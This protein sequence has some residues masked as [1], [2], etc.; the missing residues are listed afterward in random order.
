[1]Q[2]KLYKEQQH[3][4]YIRPY[5]AKINQMLSKY[6]KHKAQNRAQTNAAVEVKVN[7]Q[8]RRTMSFKVQV[9]PPKERVT[10][11]RSYGHNK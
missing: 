4:N 3:R 8:F 9:A 1:M 11:Q 10:L 6:N 2:T 7:H 5:K